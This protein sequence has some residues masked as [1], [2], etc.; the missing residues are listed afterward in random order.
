M[1]VVIE[2]I[3]KHRG[4]H[5]KSSIRHQTDNLPFSS[6]GQPQG[7][8]RSNSYNLPALTVERDLAVRAVEL[9]ELWKERDCYVE[10]LEAWEEV[11]N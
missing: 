7:D 8:H 11:G 2:R 3:C 6:C 9:L 10:E 5:G 1:P 4:L